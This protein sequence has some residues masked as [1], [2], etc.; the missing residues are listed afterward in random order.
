MR[1]NDRLENCRPALLQHRQRRSLVRLHQTRVAN[2]V[3]DDDCCKTA[4]DT[5]FGHLGNCTRGGG[6]APMVFAPRV[7]VLAV[8]D[9]EKHPTAKRNGRELLNKAVEVEAG[10]SR[11]S[12]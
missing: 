8:S 9:L 1:A 10:L 5:F 7:E 4:L 11:A 6:I 2:D 12:R 3:S